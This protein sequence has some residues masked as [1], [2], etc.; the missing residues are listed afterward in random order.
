MTPDRDL[1]DELLALE[2]R[3]CNAIS[4]GDID[5]LARMLSEDYVHVHMNAAVDDRNGHLQAIAKRP[6]RVERGEINVRV[7]GDLAVLMGEQIN[8]MQQADG[9]MRRVCAYCQ[10]VVLRNAGVW[11][12]VSFQLTPIDRAG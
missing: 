6:R 9:S 10:Q 11:R 12:F 4:V 1:Q 3:R 8:F 2:T 7:F 5:A